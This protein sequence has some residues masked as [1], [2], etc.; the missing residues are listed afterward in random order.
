M[1]AQM[2]RE[3]V[4][5][6]VETISARHEERISELRCE[7]SALETEMDSIRSFKRLVDSMDDDEF[8]PTTN[9]DTYRRELTMAIQAI[10]SEDGPLH[11][12]DILHRVQDRGVYVGGK[13]P[14]DNLAT[15]LSIDPRFQSVGR[16]YW[17]LERPGCRDETETDGPTVQMDETAVEAESD[18][19][20]DKAFL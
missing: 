8:A 18:S 12:M 9:R 2:T 16:G 20:E 7:I 15:Y 1:M 11:R 4:E 17:S 10:L 13:K 14:I 6:L 3:H 5:A 19:A